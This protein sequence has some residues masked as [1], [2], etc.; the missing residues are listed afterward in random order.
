MQSIKHAIGQ[1]AGEEAVALLE[2]VKR[3][4]HGSID[5]GRALAAFERLTH[6]L[7]SLAFLEVVREA[8]GF[9]SRP[10][11]L[12]LGEL[13]QAR[14]RYAE[15][16]TAGLM[17]QG[18]QDPREF[19]LALQALHREDPDLVR[20]LLGSEFRDLPVMKLALA[21]LAGVAAKRAA[22]TADR[23]S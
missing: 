3:G 19:A 16:N 8:I 23:R 11:R 22:L 14:A 9:L 17:K 20:Q 2:A 6:A 4:D 7:D 18:L 10:Q 12:A 15:V 13:L 21:A 5:A 1:T